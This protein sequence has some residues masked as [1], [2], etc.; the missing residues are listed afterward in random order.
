M[1]SIL[2]PPQTTPHSDPPC[3]P[4]ACTTTAAAP[5]ELLTQ[6]QMAARLGISRRTLATWV[7]HKTVPMIKVRGFCRF[8]PAKV[9]AALEQYEQKVAAWREE[10]ID[11]GKDYNGVSVYGALRSLMNTTAP[12]TAR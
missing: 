4:E 12:G 5:A 8:D 1:N 6:V 3:K 9:L 11:P 2:T 10:G 7:R